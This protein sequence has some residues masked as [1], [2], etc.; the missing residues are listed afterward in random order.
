MSS[1]A[2]N[3]P[4]EPSRAPSPS[5]AGD[6]QSGGRLYVV[7][8]AAVVSQA[9]LAHA[10]EQ[11]PAPIAIV[12]GP[13]LRFLM[14]NAQF[15]QLAGREDLLG[16][17]LFAAVP[18]HLTAG[19]EEIFARVRETGQAVYGREY[20]ITQGGVTRYFDFV[21]AP[22]GP[23]HG[24][25]D[26]ILIHGVDITAQVH[27][28]QRAEQAEARLRAVLEQLPAGVLVAEAPSG[29]LVLANTR[30][31]ELLGPLPDRVAPPAEAPPASGA[32]PSASACVLDLLAQALWH[33]TVIPPTDLYYAA[34]DGDVGWLAATAGPVYD[35]R[36]ERVA[37]IAAFSD[38]TPRHRLAVEQAALAE[39]LRLAQAAAGIVS[40]EWD[41]T[42]D[43]VHCTA[44]EHAL[45]GG[46]RAMSL[47]EFAQLLHPDDRARVIAE[48][49]AAAAAG[50]ELVLQF[51]LVRP[52]GTVREI[53]ARGR[54]VV[55]PEGR[56]RMVGVNVDITEQER[57]QRQ[58][59]QLAAASL[60]INA[61][62]TTAE[63]LRLITEHARAIIGAHE[64]VTS[65]TRGPDWS[66]AISAVSLSDK[67]AA[68]RD[69]DV[70]PDGSGIYAEVC[71]TNRPMRLTQ[72]E[73]EAHPLW[74]GFGREAGRHPPLRGWLA[75]P[76]V[77]RD[78]R[79]LGLI[80]LSDKYEGEFTEQDEAVLVQLAQL[81]AVALENAALYE[82]EQAARAEAEA[83]VRARDEFLSIAAHELRTPVTGLKGAVQLLLRRHARGT[84][85]PAR[86]A[87]SLL[88]LDAAVDRLTALVEDLLD[89]SRIRTGRLLLTR[90]PT[91]L[92]ALLRRAVAQLA[93]QGD[94]AQR[95]QLDLPP[96]LPLLWVDPLR[97]DQVLTNLLD[98]AL[99][100]SPQGGPVRVI[101]READGGVEVR[102]ED[103]GIGL[104]PGSEERIFEPFGRAPNAVGSNLP[105]MGLGLY[106][107]RNI[108]ERHGGRIWAASPG[109][110]AGA[111][112]AFWLPGDPAAPG[113]P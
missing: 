72:A 36:G 22:L 42:T 6:P 51:R 80:Q 65:L 78:G 109:E 57:A 40:F 54:V 74:R 30:A 24:P 88:L 53:A 27:G 101:A 11:V 35:A 69:Y 13:E 81:A 113:G 17:P 43:R 86:L 71:R 111:T 67:Y 97:I 26:A 52:D 25:P 10:L 55:G 31:A 92:A 95:I 4:S 110:N 20:A 73:L 39:R 37:A 7:D 62:R 90:V 56:R 108:V 89:V 14:A 45:A 85:D 21:C 32:M 64:A 107:C 84:L 70:P 23:P 38:A 104:P 99:K 33:G 106:V 100:Y 96:R 76:L 103:S 66:Q 105:G 94:A 3:Q 15:R 112:F 5:P 82:A 75:V 2:P 77:G 12:Q 44:D 61:A 48:A 83:A 60:A 87:D 47:D 46:T 63:R 79:N 19:T 9:A 16:R 50:R 68:W 49:R 41:L 18:R 29:R 58:V 8:A 91:N 34:A 28:R 102:V 98:N 59:R 93:E 1:D